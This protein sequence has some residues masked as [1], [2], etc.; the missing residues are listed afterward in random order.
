MLQNHKLLLNIAAVE[1]HE[2]ALRRKLWLG[3]ALGKRRAL[4]EVEAEERSAPCDRHA[5]AASLTD[6]I[7]FGNVGV[8]R[9]LIR[10]VVRAR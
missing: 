7:A 4:K 6:A 5:N 8:L 2:P 3:R 10:Y 1:Y 9:D